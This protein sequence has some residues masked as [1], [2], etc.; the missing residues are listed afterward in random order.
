MVSRGAIKY[1]PF[2]ALEGHKEAL[3]EK[4]KKLLHVERPI[5][6]EDDFSRINDSLLEV[7][8]NHI[9]AK[10]YIFRKNKIIE[11]ESK[12]Y[13]ILNGYLHLEDDKIL[14]TDITNIEI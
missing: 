14:I 10:F 12:V 13:K 4:E 6:S 7:I 1:Q 11:V 5:L 9:T 3:E 8:N 2:N